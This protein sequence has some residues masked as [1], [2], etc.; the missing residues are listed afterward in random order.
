MLIREL[1]KNQQ[2]V[3]VIKVPS[4]TEKKITTSEAKPTTPEGTTEPSGKIK[5]LKANDDIETVVVDNTVTEKESQ[6]S[7][8][9]NI[10][11]KGEEM[12][13]DGIALKGQENEVSEAIND[14]TEVNSFTQPAYGKNESSDAGERKD[15]G[16]EGEDGGREGE[17]GG[18]ER[19]DEGGEGE[20]GGGEVED[21]GEGEVGGGK[22]EDGGDE[23][24]GEDIVTVENI[25]EG[26]ST[27][28]TDD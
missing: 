20:D 1:V 12:T 27:N 9:S 13:E 18:R 3:S 10:E 21:G 14:E 6:G 22:G 5:F 17:D 28:I 15:G 11:G 24:D 2:N 16:V 4:S 8:H 7:S 23:D 25:E 19:E 26:K